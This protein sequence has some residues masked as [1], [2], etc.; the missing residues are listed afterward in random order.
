VQIPNE[1]ID[2]FYAGSR[3]DAV[4][5]VI[6]DTVRVRAGLHAGRTGAVV[7]IVSLEPEATFLIEPGTEPYGDFQA[8]QSILELAE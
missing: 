3:T 5:F 2:Q 7:S 6:N 1:I 4:R 8:P